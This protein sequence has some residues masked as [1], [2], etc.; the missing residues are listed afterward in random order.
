MLIGIDLGTT[1]SLAACYI[2]GEARIIPNRFGEELT[3]SVVSINEK[4]EVLVGT[5]ALEYGRTH[6]L[7]CAKVFKRAMGTPKKFILQGRCFSAPELSAIVL[8]SL[9]EDAQDYLGCEVDQAIIS[10]PAYFNELQRSATAQAGELAGLNVVRIINEPS[11]A[12]LAYGAGPY[13][14]EEKCVVFDLGGGTLDVSILDINSGIIEVHAIAG[15]NFTGGED[16]TRVLADIFLEKALIAPETLDIK[17]MNEVTR[18]AEKAKIQLSALKSVNMSCMI[19]NEVIVKTIS[20]SEFN[21]KCKELKNRIRRPV[22]RA[23][24]D[25]GLR[26]SD[27]DRVLLVG[28]ATKLPMVR[29]YVAG[30]FSAFPQMGVDPV[31]AVA[32]GAAMACG[33][34]ERKEE[35]KEIIFIDVC[36]FTLGTEIVVFNGSFDE[37]GHYMPIIERNTVIPVSRSQTVYT[38]HDDQT[39]VCVKILQGE[40]RKAEGNLRLGEITVPVPAAPAGEESVNITYTYDINSL[41]EVEVKVNS[42]GEK[43]RL[44]IQ[45]GDTGLTDAELA[46]R[47]KRLEYLKRNPK[48]DERN[49]LLLLRGERLYEESNM[50]DRELIDREMMKFE[51]ILFGQD[52]AKIESAR[53]HLKEIF[54]GIER[55]EYSH[56]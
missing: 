4:D 41:L 50:D 37:P 39:R 16:F 47:F 22:E 25:S 40:S 5:L 6:P 19:A 48:D 38:A 10:V 26:L 28:G 18:V 3:P 34:K 24:R 35:L 27:I 12:A 1:N 17:T 29:N 32:V 14:A 42:T 9:K 15:D 2:D 46:E 54:D 44:I 43:R 56:Q 11:A 7:D 30:L 45:N 36:P 51:R 33:M 53:L 49:A 21:S 8:R 52:R 31:K 55:P 13:G 23:I 20:E